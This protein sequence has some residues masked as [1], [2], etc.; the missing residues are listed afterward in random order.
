[1]MKLKTTILFKVAMFL[2]FMTRYDVK[3]DFFTKHGSLPYGLVVLKIVCFY[4]NISN[5][6]GTFKSVKNISTD[7]ETCNS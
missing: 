5:Q 6:T 2:F 1:M 7:L 4:K 3:S